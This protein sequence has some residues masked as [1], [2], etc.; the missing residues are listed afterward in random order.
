MTA[1]NGKTKGPPKPVRCAIYTRKST[2]EGLDRD[3]NTLEAQRDG[4]LHYIESQVSLGWTVVPTRYDDGGFTGA[5]LERPALQALLDDIERGQVDMV[6]VYKVDRLSR[7]LLDFAR[8]ME[9]FEKKSIGFVSITQS[10]DTSTS[11]GRLILN[12]LLSFAQFEREMIA[13]RTSDKIQAAKKRG[14]WTGGAVMLGY[15][16]DKEKHGLVV[17]PEEAELVRL[18]FDLY[19]RLHSTLLV[20]QR[21]NKQGFTTKR[22]ISGNGRVVGGRVW[23]KVAV[24]TILRNPIYVGKIRGKDGDL[25]RG[26]HEA[27]IPL[28]VFE[29]VGEMLESRGHPH[30]ARAA[31]PSRYL[32]AGILRCGPCKSAMIPSTTRKNGREYRYYRCLHS[33]DLGAEACPTGCISCDEVKQAVVDSVKA[34][35]KRGEVQK[36]IVEHLFGG[37]GAITEAREIRTRL[38]KRLIDLNAEATRLFD[39]FKGNAAGSKLMAA[40]VGEVE[41]EADGVRTRIAELNERLR[42]LEEAQ[43]EAKKVTNILDAFD[44][45]W[46]ALVT[47][48]KRQ[49]LSLLMDHVTVDLAAGGLSIGFHDFAVPVARRQGATPAPEPATAVAAAKEVQP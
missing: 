42:S 40:R 12:V 23:G 21:L 39:S 13:E 1:G 5:N 25:Y 18:I 3:Y 6:V 17:A 32:L 35:A 36:R 27:I 15:A 26:E 46:S 14:K 30:P 44:A 20:A 19:Q 48:E 49:L 10:F 24:H 41:A 16:V 31:K 7:S 29:R 28:E 11:M 34:V 22:H 9:Q 33:Q 45:V 2:T 8:L 37:E 43:R 47:I 38:E 4:C